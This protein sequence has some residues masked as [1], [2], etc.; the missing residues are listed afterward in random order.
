[1]ITEDD[2]KKSP[3]PTRSDD[4]LDREAQALRDNLR[5][6]KEQARARSQQAPPSRPIQGTEEKDT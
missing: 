2:T 6:R 3:L 1:M 5:R 4:R